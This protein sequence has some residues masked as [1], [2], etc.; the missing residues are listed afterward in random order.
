MAANGAP[1][2]SIGVGRDLGVGLGS[3]AALTGEIR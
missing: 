3:N 1:A 2:L